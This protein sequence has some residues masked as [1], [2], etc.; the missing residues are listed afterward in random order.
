MLRTE[1]I[2]TSVASFVLFFW[3]PFLVVCNTAVT[4]HF[5][6]VFHSVPWFVAL[7]P[8][9]QNSTRRRKLYSPEAVA[10][11]VGAA[12][13]SLFLERQEEENSYKGRRYS[14]RDFTFSD[15][16]HRA[17]ASSNEVSDYGIF[18]LLWLMQVRCSSVVVW[19]RPPLHIQHFRW[20][21]QKEGIEILEEGEEEDVWEIPNDFLV[22]SNGGV[23]SFQ[24]RWPRSA[25]R[26]IS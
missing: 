26:I 12:R 17:V 25:R 3:M 13:S 8:F 10:C 6:Q 4:L 19:Y 20:R 23:D 18:H 5:D 21:K 11:L 2:V 15:S 24:S 9:L 16:H 22:V 14:S 1:Q 7:Q